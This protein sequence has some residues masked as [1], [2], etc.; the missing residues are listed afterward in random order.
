MKKIL[1][2]LS[3]LVLSSCDEG[4]SVIDLRSTGDE[5]FDKI[6]HF[7][8]KSH[9]YIMFRKDLGNSGVAGVVH[10]PDCKCNQHKSKLINIDN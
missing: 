1:I 8:Y 5:I 9:D 10:D 4:T 2:I 7:K 6:Y 3:A